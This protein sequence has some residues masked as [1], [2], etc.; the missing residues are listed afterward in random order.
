MG[1][2]RV[3][4]THLLDKLP[5][6]Y[7]LSIERVYFYYYI[8]S[9]IKVL[10][11][12]SNPQKNC[13]DIGANKGDLTLF[14]CKFCSHVYCFEPTSSLCECLERRF[15]GR[16][17]SVENC[18]LGRSRS[19]SYLNIPIVGN[20]KIETRSSLIVDFQDKSIWGERV[21]NVE[22]MK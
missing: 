17:V 1:I 3:I 15:R 5:I 2:R 13:L 12:L 8:N 6:A 9:D 20:K 14:L 16:N 18:A 21:T 4:R 10:K 11:Q 7:R 19:E 22:K